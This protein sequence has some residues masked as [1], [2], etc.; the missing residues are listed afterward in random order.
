[1]VSRCS[2]QT[3]DQMFDQLAEHQQCSAGLW[4]MWMRQAAPMT[5]SVYEQ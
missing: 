5:S 1:M 4:C 3:F 2:D